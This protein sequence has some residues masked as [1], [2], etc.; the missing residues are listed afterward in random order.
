M[1]KENG[2]EI[3]S[4]GKIVGV[5]LPLV[6]RN[7]F[8]YRVQDG[9]EVTIG[10]YV[11][12]PFGNKSVWGVVW[13]A[14]QGGIDEKKIKTIEM[15][16]VHLPP[17]PEAMRKFIEW[18]SWYTL[19]P[20]GMVLKMALSAPDALNPPAI[21]VH[22]KLNKESQNKI[23]P[24]RARIVA[25]LSDETPRTAKDI[26]TYAKVSAHVVREFI[27][28]EGL[29]EILSIPARANIVANAIAVTPC[30]SDAQK[31]AA[32]LLR[33]KINAGFSVTVLDGVTGS[34]KTEVY[35]DA[36]DAC[37][38]QNKQVLVM[39]P[40]IA[41]S[42]QWLARFKKRF[43][44][45]PDV[46][47]SNVK[48][49]KKRESWRGV[50]SG[51]VKI[52][53][54]ARS[55]LFMPFSNLALIIVDEEH[56][57]SYKQEDG[58]IYQARDMAV[59]RAHQE[60]IPIVLVSATPSLETEY[61]IENKRYTRVHLPNRHN[62][63]EMPVVQLIDMRVTPP[64]RGKWISEPLRNAIIKTLAEK[65]QAM[66]FMNRRGYAP[67]MLCRACGH[68]FQ[69]PDCTSWLVLHRAKNK[70]LCH[71]CGYTAP[72]PKAC[73]ECKKENTIVPYGPGVERIAEE[74]CELFPNAR[75][76][77]MTSDSADEN[78]I[79]SMTKGEIDIL[80][81]TQ[82][83]AKGHHF[84]GLALVGVI[85]ADMGLAG[86][87]LRAGERT[88][89]LLH[90][91]SGRAGRE[92]TKGEVYLQTYM[93]EHPVMQALAAGDR[94]RFMMLEARMREDA[95]MPPYGKLA[96]VIIEGQ[97]EQE[98]A[99]FARE[100][101]RLANSVDTRRSGSDDPAG[102]AAR[103]VD[104]GSVPP[105]PMILGPAPAPLLRLSGKYRYRILIKAERNFP[106]QQ[107]LA[108]WLLQHKIPAAF[109][110]KI[111]VEPYSFV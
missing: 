64:E 74:L 68:R 67:L 16:A 106:L 76:K 105:M 19:T 54:G 40:E 30:L 72:V 55:A 96:A 47:H 61:N 60:K 56:D 98:V 28:A 51:N 7:P 77:V 80:V 48:P 62:E 86:G 81:G 79:D 90:Q 65:N 71:H 14:A 46:W 8:D 38:G 35:F 89:Q 43:G 39:L 83:I 13:G 99:G 97:N 27:K 111:D 63:A 36:I 101:V 26:A 102:E 31:N 78:I 11:R 50:A 10:D 41:L 23:T 49:S 66:I 87:D 109:K 9:M 18:V 17:I 95:E 15:I 5:L 44:F 24:A 93:P 42:V 82:M 92:K 4:S 12:V 108:D 94:D 104:G 57:P 29:K 22:Y 37:I 70:L 25:Y 6:F 1:L 53:V 21:D 58:A 69:C 45:E 107:W 3:I 33:N 34:G 110:I 32:D 75:I 20:L 103:S 2:R 73:P 88:Y 84:A 91:L 52:I 100:L 85:D 59:A